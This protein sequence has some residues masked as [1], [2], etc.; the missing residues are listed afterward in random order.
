MIQAL[1]HNHALS[2]WKYQRMGIHGGH[3]RM[4]MVRNTAQVG[5]GI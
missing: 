1:M 3:K 5:R 2:Y 4:D